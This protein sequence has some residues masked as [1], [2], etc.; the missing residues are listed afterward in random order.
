MSVQEVTIANNQKKKLLKVIKD[1]A[2]LF[3]DDNG[4]LVVNVAT[5]KEFKKELRVMQ[6]TKKGVETTPIEA[7]VGQDLLD[8]DA[9]Y[10]I[11]S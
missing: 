1:E 8:F 10:F 11:F 4:D 7:I 5:Y 9:E 2:V 6:N 3:Q